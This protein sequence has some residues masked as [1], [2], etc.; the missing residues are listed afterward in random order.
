MPRAWVIHNYSGY[1]GLS[2][3][4]FDEQAPGPGEIRLKVEAFAL[5]WGDMDLMC[6]RYSFSF[7]EFPARIGIE[8][9]G[10]VDAVGPGVSGIE[11]GERYCTLPYFYYD[12]GASTESLVI[13]AHYV[14]KAPPNLSA[15]ES[16]SIWMQYLTAYF[17]IVEISNAAPGKHFL[18]TAATGTAGTAALQI[19]KHC[20]AT[21]IAT[22][23]YSYNRAYLED[24]GADHVLIAGSGDLADQLREITN[25][26]GID[27]AFDPIGAGMIGQ[28]AP[29]LARDARIYFYGTLDEELPT[30]PM[31]EMFQANA[32]FQPYSVFNY[33]E[34]EAMC[35]KGKAFIYAA[36]SSGA[37]A[38][39]IDRIFPME[40]YRDAWDYLKAPRKSHGK[41]VV[42][43][44]L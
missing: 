24:A 44:G 12:R 38:P 7:R 19:G 42:E 41:V 30:L 36:L 9:A 34:N 4:T 40:G 20:G 10:I 27:A 32:V 15:V 8:A 2:L 26:H 5:N 18:I 43:I 31:T 28:Y 23:R 33:V 16:A 35:A 14:T 22:S 21:M 39:R 37:I 29:A 11:P 1:Q 25:G 17:P 3:E 13:D 6:D